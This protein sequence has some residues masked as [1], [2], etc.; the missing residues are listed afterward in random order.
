MNIA[1][2]QDTERVGGRW[3]LEKANWTEF[4]KESEKNLAPVS[5]GGNDGQGHKAGDHISSK[6]L[7]T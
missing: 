3:I 5:E 6:Q 7:Y 1:T 2:V 4:T